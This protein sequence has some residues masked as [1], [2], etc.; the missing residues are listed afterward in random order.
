MN[1]GK[2]L[3]ADYKHMALLKFVGE[4]RVVMSSTLDNYCNNLYAAYFYKGITT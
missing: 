3:A 1:A 4:V 2:I